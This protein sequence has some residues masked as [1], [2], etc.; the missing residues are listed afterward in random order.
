MYRTHFFRVQ[1]YK[2]FCTFARFI[3]NIYH[4]SAYLYKNSQISTKICI[5]ICIFHFFFVT[6]C[7]YYVQK[8]LLNTKQ[9]TI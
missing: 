5:I 1:R 6:L 9:Q 4:F 2:K 7:S 3:E 8:S